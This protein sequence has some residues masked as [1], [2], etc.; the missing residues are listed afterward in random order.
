MNGTNSLAG[1]LTE[2]LTVSPGSTARIPT[3][4]PATDAKAVTRRSLYQHYP[5]SYPTTRLSHAGGQEQASA[6]VVV[7]EAPRRTEEQPAQT[8]GNRTSAQTSQR[9]LPRVVIP[10]N[11]TAASLSAPRS[12][13]VPQ[14]LTGVTLVVLI[15]AYKPDERLAELVTRLLGARRDCAVLVV[16]DGSGQ[17]YAP[18]FAA[19][20]AH[21][22]QVVSY[23]VNQ[24]KGQ[25]LRTGLAHA[26]AT[27]PE[28]DVVCADADGQHTP[29]DIEAVAAR[30][31]ETGHI[32][33]GVRRFTGPVPLRSRIGNDVTALLFRG[34]TGWRL[35]DTQTG[36]RGYPAGHL[37]WLQSVPGDR[38]EYELSTLLRAH[39][40][41]LAVE[42]VE[43]ATVYEP[44]NT[45]SHFRPLQDS[46]RIYAPLLRFIGASLASFGIDWLGVM[47]IF[48][49]TGNLLAAVVGARLI[50]GT[51]NFFMNRRVFRARRGTV[52]RTALRYVA[53]ALSLLAASYLMLKALTVIGIPLGIAKILGDGAIYAASYVA[54]RRLVF[55]ERG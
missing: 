45:S 23:P 17:Q 32:T 29:S 14:P 7:G 19:A 24:G 27:W 22:A 11:R 13:A 1:N 39:E 20:R 47:V 46:A 54:Q 4:T 2:R 49:M 43:I 53:L 5:Q 6:T 44:G 37:S 30:V 41:G 34:A 36:L 40:L 26:A 25:A 28:A 15:P 33:L 35:G 42:Q 9:V 51:A 55:K 18:F 31:R 8:T 16:D 48:A 38:Y 12:T 52:T 50:S 21:G 3:R 10:A